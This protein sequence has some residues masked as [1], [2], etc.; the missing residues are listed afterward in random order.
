[1]SD[2]IYVGLYGVGA[3]FDG[4]SL[5]DIRR[6]KN[7]KIRNE[8]I[9]SKQILSKCCNATIT[10]GDFASKCDECGNSVNP[11]TGEPYNAKTSHFG[12]IN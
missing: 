3:A 7:A 8:E 9:A 2:S 12:G 4:R 5:N 10:I 11:D 1:M 6:Q